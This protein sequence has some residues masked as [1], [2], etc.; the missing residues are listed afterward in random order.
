MTDVPYLS[1]QVDLLLSV[2]PGNMPADA[3]YSVYVGDND[4]R[5]ATVTFLKSLPIPVIRSRLSLQQRL[6]SLRR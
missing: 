3:L 2:I 6:L 5:D 1:S 4:V